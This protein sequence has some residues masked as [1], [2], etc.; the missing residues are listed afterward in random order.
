[1]S[2]MVHVIC[3]HVK[4]PQSDSRVAWHVKW[5]TRV[6]PGAKCSSGLA[7]VY[8]NLLLVSDRLRFLLWSSLS[9]AVGIG[10]VGLE[11]LFGFCPAFHIILLW[12][13]RLKFQAD[14]KG[15]LTFC[16][17]SLNWLILPAVS[18]WYKL[19]SNF[20]FVWPHQRE[21]KCMWIHSHMC[22]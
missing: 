3:V 17:D 5:E 7:E 2:D 18:S 1:M 16:V 15:R 12:F 9:R 8:S 4:I 14:A 11:N 10:D 21:E 20:L 6:F 22:F 13:P 19:K